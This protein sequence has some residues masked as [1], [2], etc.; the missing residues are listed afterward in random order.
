MKKYLII[1]III[2]M[3]ILIVGFYYDK[4]LKK[5]IMDGDGMIYEYINK[6]Q[7]E[8]NGQVLNINLEDNDATR[9]LVEKLKKDKITI[10]M[11]DYGNFEKVGNLGFNLQTEDKNMTTEAGDVILYQGNQLVLFYGSNTWS[12]TKLGHINNIN[13]EELKNILGNSK[14]EI[15][16]KLENSD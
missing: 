7:I 1:L 12:Y 5:N 13:K 16:L 4:H 6:I 8:V 11:S 2:V 14:I 10:S 3:M 15:T 9:E